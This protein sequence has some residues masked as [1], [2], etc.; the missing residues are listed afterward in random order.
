MNDRPE[1]A[2]VFRTYEKDFFAKWGHVLNPQQRKAFAAIRDCRTAAL[3]G[4]VEY[5]EQ[6]D[7]CGHLVNAYNSCRD[8]HCPKCQ[9]A[10]R[11]KWMAARES[12]LLPVPYFHV[13]FTLPREIGE[14][15]LQNAREIYSI[16]FRAA[17]ETLLTISADPKRLG[18][19]VG[20]LAVLHT[21]GQNLHL[22]PHLHCVVP[23]GGIAPD[24]AK[25]IGCRKPSFLLPIPVLK[26]RF[27]NV[28]LIYLREAFDDGRLKFHGEMA[29]LARPAAFVALCNR[30]QRIKW[31]VH[32]KAPFGGPEQVLK[33][34]ARYTHRVAISNSRILSVADGK[35]IFQ[36][37]DYADG[38][39]T[40]IMT[41][42]AVEFIRRFLL[43]ILPG[44]FVR[45]RQFGFLANRARREKLALCRTLLNAP[46]PLSN[47]TVA[48]VP[49]R[50]TD[51]KRCPVCRTGHMILIRLFRTERLAGVP[52]R[53]DSS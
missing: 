45:I 19:A 37:K 42:D 52:A 11:A 36:W 30:M 47:A 17:S 26:S 53:I 46:A 2:D 22:H 3:G 12:E 32:A 43:H 8:R 34:L 41:L 31:N 39:K 4:H 27:R 6:C 21:W 13:V 24:G 35:V 23:G 9:A 33:Y 18:A 50:K 49:D 7:T 25:W 20:F 51:E 16:L 10:A 48:G 14:L 40:K 28:F 5:V 44:G 38:N 1:V 15:A 29:E